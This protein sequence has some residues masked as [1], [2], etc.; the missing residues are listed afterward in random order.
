[1]LFRSP[2]SPE[3]ICHPV[4]TMQDCYQATGEGKK[5][6]NN[7]PGIYFLSGT[8]LPPTFSRQLDLM[9]A[10]ADEE[11]AVYMNSPRQKL[12]LWNERGV[13]DFAGERL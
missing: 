9:I 10:G 5:A 2:E 11:R 7:F 1:M 3:I 4:G 12:M 8:I 6:C 13:G